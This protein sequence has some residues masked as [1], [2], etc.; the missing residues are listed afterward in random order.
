MEYFKKVYDRRIVD[1]DVFK[2]FQS[3]GEVIK[4]TVDPRELTKDKGFWKLEEEY[5]EKARTFIN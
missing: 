3:Q 5:Q 4:M 1:F 2:K